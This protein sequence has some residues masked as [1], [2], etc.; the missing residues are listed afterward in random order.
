M[1][2]NYIKD[3]LVPYNPCRTLR[4]S[5]NNLLTVPKY[6]CKAYG[7]RMFEVRAPQLWNSLPIELRGMTSLEQF[8]KSLK[9]YLFRL[10]FD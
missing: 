8:K 1:A 7:S 5:N 4:S 9:T 10:A 3:L 6:R 2:P